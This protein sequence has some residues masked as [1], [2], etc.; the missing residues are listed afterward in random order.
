MVSHPLSAFR[1]TT[2]AE[3]GAGVR[4][5]AAEIPVGARPFVRT[6]SLLALKF[7][8]TRLLDALAPGCR[9]PAVRRSPSAGRLPHTGR[10]SLPGRSPRPSPR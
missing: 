2:G 8:A 6:S 10:P 9:S 5:V 4:L 1:L 3:A 7:D